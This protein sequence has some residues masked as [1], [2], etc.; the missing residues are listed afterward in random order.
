[1]GELDLK[2]LSG[3][4][5]ARIAENGPAGARDRVTAG[6]HC[7]GDNACSRA[8]ERSSTGPA[9]GSSRSFG[10]RPSG[11][12]LRPSRVRSARARGS[13]PS[14]GAASDPIEPGAKLVRVGDDGRAA[15]VGVERPAVRC[16]VAERLVLLVADGGHRRNGTR[17]DRA[18]TT[19]W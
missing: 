4:D 11:S 16:K 12:R 17:R 18:R 13:R 6:E 3:G 19:H 15:A 2:E 8:A 7:E 1:M 10:A 14:R 9:V 5:G